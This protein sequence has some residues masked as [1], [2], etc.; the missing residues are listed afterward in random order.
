MKKLRIPDN[1]TTLAYRSIKDYILESDLDEETRLTE[2]LFSQRLGISKSPIREA[3]TRL[4]SEGLLRIEPRRG[5]YLRTFS[6]KEIRDLYGVREALELYAIREAV[7]TRELLQALA[8]SV[9]RQQDFLSRGDKANYIQE[10]VQFHALLAGATGNQYLCATLENLQNQILLIRRK[11]F[12][13]SSSR[14]TAAHVSIL[15]A[16]EQEDKLRAEKLMR[17]HI[18][19]VRR[20][21]ID[22][23]LQTE[24]RRMLATG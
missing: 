24:N 16:L 21:L 1:L 22:H 8:A 14:A 4:E 11:T 6:L 13:L 23:L 2:E 3:L 15:R 19:S 9:D 10:D 7:I 17:E 20:R 12:D 5:A 18:S